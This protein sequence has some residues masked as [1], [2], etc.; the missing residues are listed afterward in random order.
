MVVIV[1]TGFGT[2]DSAITAMREGAF[3]YL[4]KPVSMALIAASVQRGLAR[5]R[6]D[7]RHQ[8][9]MRSLELALHE[10]EQAAC[11]QHQG[12]LAERDRFLQTP[13]LVI[14]RQKRLVVLDNQP[15]ELTPTEFDFLDC[16]A[17]H[18]DHVVTASDLIRAA[19]GDHV[20]DEDARP[21]VRVHLQRLRRKT[22]R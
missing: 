12:E 11:A 17:A 22:W 6:E 5:R 1:L 3:D 7:V 4:T 18:S 13:R 14:D 8:Q 16:L 10:L 2:L 9:L 20:A 19:H 15:V 21:M